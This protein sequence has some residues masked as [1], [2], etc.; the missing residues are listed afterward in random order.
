MT[1]KYRVQVF[2]LFRGHPIPVRPAEFFSVG[3]LAARE[4]IIRQAKKLTGFNKVRTRTKDLGN[5]ILLIGQTHQLNID[6]I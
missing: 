1:D 6:Y 3:H 5:T 2:R 4:S